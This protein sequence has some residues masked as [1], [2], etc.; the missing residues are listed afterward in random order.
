M[1]LYSVG[2]ANLGNSLTQNGMLIQLD[3]NPAYSQLECTAFEL[4]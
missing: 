4:C 3:A 1:S 2:E